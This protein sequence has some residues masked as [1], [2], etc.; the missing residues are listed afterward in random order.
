MNSLRD[1]RKVSNFP[2]CIIVAAK[3]V[4]VFRNY[5]SIRNDDMKGFIYNVFCLE[6]ASKT[7]RV[8]SMPP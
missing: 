7:V 5:F 6:S 2:S 1:I 3:N 8:G 4:K